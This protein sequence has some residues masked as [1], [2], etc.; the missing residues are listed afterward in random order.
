MRKSSGCHLKTKNSCPD[1]YQ[2]TADDRQTTGRRRQTTGRRPSDD[3][4]RIG[5]GRFQALT[6]NRYTFARLDQYWNPYLDRLIP[7]LSWS[8]V[9]PV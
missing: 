7:G 8:I 4:K 1:D 9:Y 6:Q 5:H 2:T 3:R